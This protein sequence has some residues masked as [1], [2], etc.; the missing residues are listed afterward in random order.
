MAASCAHTGDRALPAAGTERSP[1]TRVS[2]ADWTQ[3]PPRLC[4]GTLDPCEGKPLSSISHA[5]S[6]ITKFSRPTL[7][8]SE[9]FLHPLPALAARLDPVPRWMRRMAPS[10]GGW[11][12]D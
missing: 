6:G 7:A 1:P 4:E 3:S 10:G 12:T 5:D 11:L 8:D 2:R 9:L